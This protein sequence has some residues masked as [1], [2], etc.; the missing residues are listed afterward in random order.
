M[1]QINNQFNSQLTTNYKIYIYFF[2]QQTLYPFFDKNSIKFIKSPFKIANVAI[3]ISNITY[4]FP[5]E[6]YL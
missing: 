1:P 6:I 3:K 2:F 4:Y 5:R